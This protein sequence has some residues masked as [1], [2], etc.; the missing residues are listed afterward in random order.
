MTH[1][2]LDLTGGGGTLEIVLS[3]KAAEITGTTTP[4]AL[5]T[6]WPKIADP[7]SPTRG[8]R[9]AHAD[10]DGKFTLSGLAP[11]DYYAAAWEDGEPGLMQSPEFVR[12]FEAD[13]A[14][15]VSLEE[16]GR[17]SVTVRLISADKIAAALAMI[18]W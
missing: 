6:L 5:V 15:S 14:A 7:G 1:A 16:G 18:T 11:G 3:P 10:Q 17:K 12:Q 2:P 13:G 4:D 9:S 8:S